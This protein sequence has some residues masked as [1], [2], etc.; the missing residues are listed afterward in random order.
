MSEQTKVAVFVEPWLQH[1]PSLR[2]AL[3]FVSVAQRPLFCAFGAL[4]HALRETVLI[5]HEPAVR[6]AKSAWWAE[7]LQ[8]LG[9]GRPQHPLSQALAEA[10]SAPWTQVAAGIL[11]TLSAIDDAPVD[12][13][14]ALAQVMP[15]ASA[16]AAVEAA[17][18]LS[19]SPL[20]AKA[21]A[22]HLLA[23]RLAFAR[24]DAQAAVPPLHLLARYRIARAELGGT[25]GIHVRRDYAA[26]LAA[27]LPAVESGL[28]LL[29]RLQLPL[30]RA[31][32]D[33][34]RKGCRAPPAPNL[35]RLWQLWRAARA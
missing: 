24:G 22:V 16:L 2:P 33:A 17:I 27:E 14:Q 8:R 13:A 29:R 30:D 9:A 15:L 7:E 10:G 26:E 31:L 25:G 34:V 23:Q 1:E 18:F 32:L 20:A 12:T 5:Q 11:R 4:V 35:R 6:Q 28:S 3:A 19:A 21:C